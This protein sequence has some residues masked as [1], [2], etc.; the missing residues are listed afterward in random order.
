M[1]QQHTS[2]MKMSEGG[3]KSKTTCERFIEGEHP[4][5]AFLAGGVVVSAVFGWSVAVHEEILSLVAW[6][7]T[8]RPTGG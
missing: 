5:P 1:L 2:K 7:D 3:G 6:L 8:I 4:S